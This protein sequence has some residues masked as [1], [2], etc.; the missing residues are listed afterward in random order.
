M[1]K[2]TIG[3][4]FKSTGMGACILALLFTGSLFIIASGG[5]GGDDRSAPA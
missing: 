4:F 3:K 5:G 2:V 1:S